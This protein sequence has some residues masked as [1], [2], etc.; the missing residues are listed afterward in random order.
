MTKRKAMS[1][2]GRNSATGL[3]FYNK[4]NKTQQHLNLTSRVAEIDRMR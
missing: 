4:T 1:A 2:T 3:I